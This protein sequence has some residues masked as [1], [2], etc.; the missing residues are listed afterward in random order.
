[1]KKRI[2][3]CLLSGIMVIG[4]FTGCSE[5]KGGSTARVKTEE[6]QEETEKETETEKKTVDS[7]SSLTEDLSDYSDIEWPDTE[8]TSAIP[9][10]KSSVGKI[11]FESDEGLMITL[12]NISDDDYNDY[13]D[14]CKQL[15]YTVDHVT[16]ES[17]YSAKKEDGHTIMI[18]LEDDHTMTITA[19]I[20]DN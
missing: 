13:V 6:Q 2:I 4:T 7:N 18:A 14:E 9:K 20:E 3:A 16:M 5:K 11:I 10:P 19:T 15:G 1:M 12:A 17:M 8:I